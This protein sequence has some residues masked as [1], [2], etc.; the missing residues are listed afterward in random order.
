MRLS[1]RFKQINFRKGSNMA[2]IAIF[3]SVLFTVFAVFICEVFFINHTGVNA[4]IV[5]DIASDA[6]ATKMLIVNEE[7]QD[8]YKDSDL[9][10]LSDWQ[11]ESVLRARQIELET[12]MK[13]EAA[14]TSKEIIAKNQELSPY[15][16]NYDG[17]INT[18]KLLKENEAEIQLTT[19]T[20]S[21]FMNTKRSGFDF[22]TPA[23][24]TSN[25]YTVNTTATTEFGNWAQ[26]MINWLKKSMPYCSYV[27][28]GLSY[29][30]QGYLR[31]SDCSH[32]VYA[33]YRHV[34]SQ[35]S[36]N[37]TAT[38]P[39]S[40]QWIPISRSELKPG[41]ILNSPSNHVVMY[42]GNN[43]VIECA[44]GCG[45]IISPVSHYASYSPFRIAPQFRP[46]GAFG[47]AEDTE[48][49][50]WNGQKLNRVNGTVQGP[51]GKETYYN[52]NMSGVVRIMRSMGYDEKKYPYWVRDDG[53]KMFG[54]YIM[55]AAELSLRPKGTI[56]DT[57]LGK[58]IVCDTGGFAAHNRTQLDIATNW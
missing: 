24:A 52:L 29:T 28:G 45:I 51:S 9:S 23:S 14:A 38:I 6:V 11:R 17:K 25:N 44:G 30:P 22:K 40:G 46:S 54:N 36:Y 49:Y 15:T 58:G 31:T 20:K 19:K 8:K 42:M 57:S 35:L 37:T 13:K 43:Q 55:V 16:Y 50:S 33:G 2:L 1:E 5:N 32:M 18:D 7:W 56:V 21:V 53:C 3:Y 12:N 10:G 27:W 34:G 39:N 48:L 41:D 26:E 47:T 4:Q